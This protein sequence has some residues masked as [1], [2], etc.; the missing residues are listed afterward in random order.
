MI[1]LGTDASA[2]PLIRFG[3]FELDA[4]TGELRKSGVPVNLPPQPFKILAL[5]ASRAGTLVTREEIHKQIW[6]DE[7]FVD[8]EQGLN[9]AI[10]KIRAVLGD[11]A[12]KPRYIETLPRRGYRFIAPVAPPDA[13]DGKISTTAEA[14][15]GTQRAVTALVDAVVETH[16]SRARWRVAVAA[17]AM[18][19]AGALLAAFR[20]SG[21]RDA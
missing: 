15:E 4:Q 21:Q 18:V 16:R 5:L 10:K 6:G 1:P 12:E 2:P 14:H 19:G 3:A 20:G 7:T 11:N 8:F 13:G 9:F 17:L